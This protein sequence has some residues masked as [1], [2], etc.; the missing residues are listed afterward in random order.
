MLYYVFW[1]Y[2]DSNKIDFFNEQANQII[3]I[4]LRLL[5]AALFIWLW[6]DSIINFKKTRRE[7]EQKLSYAN[8]LKSQKILLIAHGHKMFEDTYSN[9]E[10]M[11][12]IESAFQEKGYHIIFAPMLYHLQNYYVDESINVHHMLIIRSPYGIKNQ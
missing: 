2:F 5:M 3:L 6:I 7:F 1:M 12:I 10:K 9:R 8:G 4:V 11:A